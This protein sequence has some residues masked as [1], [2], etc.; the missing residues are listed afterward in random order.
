L[1]SRVLILTE[2]CRV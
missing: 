1:K 2:E